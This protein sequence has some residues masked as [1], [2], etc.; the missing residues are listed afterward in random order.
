M[1]ERI[2]TALVL[3]VVVLSCM[4]ATPS[5]Y[6]MLI[7]MV[8]V[9]TLAGDEWY[10]LMPKTDGTDVSAV[11]SKVYAAIILITSVVTLYFRDLALLLWCGAI[12]VAVFSIY[13]I[14]NYPQYDAWYNKGLTIVGTVL[15]TATVTAIFSVWLISAWW[16]M[17]LFLLVWTAD[18]GAYFVGRKL[19]KRPMVPHVS[20]KKTIEGLCGGLLTSLIIIVVV[21]SIYLDHLNLRQHSAFLL[22]S[23]LTV[24]AS[25]L[26]D[27]IESML[28]RR[29]GVKDSGTLLPGHGGIL[30]RIDSLLT[31][32]PVFAAGI[33]L[34]K[35]IGVEL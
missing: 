17:Y 29:A 3:V 30:D 5:H 23:L 34:L 4:F 20:P 21:Q 35:M 7:L 10:K 12:F 6:P 33:Y 27:L 26:G 8:I 13:C 32:A 16:L 24:L 1:F 14:K 11:A 15:I 31:A 22:L 19:G 9:A 25:V 18:S 2:K 28:K